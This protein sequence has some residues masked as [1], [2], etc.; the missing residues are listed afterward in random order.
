MLS[1]PTTLDLACPE[2][3]NYRQ[4]A[5]PELPAR[6]EGKATEDDY[7]FRPTTRWRKR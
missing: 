4:G 5:I 3:V 6:K 7:R 1:T 2:W